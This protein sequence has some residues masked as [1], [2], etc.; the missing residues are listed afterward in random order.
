[1]C[2]WSSSV[3]VRA[4]VDV[5]G[6]IGLK[7]QALVNDPARRRQDEADIV[8]LLSLHLSSLDRALLDEYFALF[9]QADALERFLTEAR[10]RRG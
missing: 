3:L 5:E 9:D 10:Q 7:L 8:A 4:R 2:P 1:M 6:L